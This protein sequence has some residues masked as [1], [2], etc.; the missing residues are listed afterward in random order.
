MKNILIPGGAGYIGSILV[1]KL[2][3][4]GYNVTVVDNLWFKSNNEDKYHENI[5]CTND[6]LVC[7]N[8]TLVCTNDNLG[9]YK[10][11]KKDLFECTENDFE[12]IDTVIFLAGVSNDPMA[13]FSPK[14]NFTQN[15]AL[16][17]FLAFIAKKAGVKRF[18]FASSCSVYGNANHK[19][20]TEDDEIKSI[21][22]YGI[23]KYQA[24]CG[25]MKLN[26][27]SFSVICLR[28]GTVVGF[29]ER[30]RFDLVINAMF[31][32]AI[33]DKKITINNPTIW[34]PII[35]IEDAT[36]AYVI[37][38][39]SPI[40]VNGIFNIACDNFTV[41]EMGEIVKDVIHELTGDAICLNIKNIVDF[42]NYRVNLDK[43]KD[44]LNFIPKKTIADT[45]KT[46]YKHRNMYNDYMDDRF[47]NIKMFKKLNLVL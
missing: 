12:C 39:D 43:S 44:I 4:K 30:M 2:L 36:D 13:E 20:F 16:P 40:S 15:T 5:V 7:T 18:I 37:A 28:K 29:S 22:P 26:D 41:L 14:I 27:D 47:Y 6:N 38:V 25:L 11:I 3:K 32:S 23:S 1:P 24:E 33:L 46:L 8:D 31:K 45:V 17:T 10:F 34:R 9:K 42:R 35:D 21:Y 19:E